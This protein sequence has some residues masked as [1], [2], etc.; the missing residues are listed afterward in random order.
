[1]AKQDETYKILY[2]IYNSLENHS[3]IVSGVTNAI[4][5][6]LTV[7]PQCRIDD[8][9]HVEGC[10]FALEVLMDIRLREYII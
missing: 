8:F 5:P 6:N 1:M 10:E 7:C 3:S 2:A 4:Q 9:Q